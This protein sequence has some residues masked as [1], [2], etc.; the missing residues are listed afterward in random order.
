VL[1]NINVE[2]QQ[3]ADAYRNQGYQVSFGPGLDVLLLASLV[4]AAGGVA[5][6]GVAGGSSRRWSG[7]RE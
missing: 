5:A 6:G 7:R 2:T 4:C 1:L 3:L